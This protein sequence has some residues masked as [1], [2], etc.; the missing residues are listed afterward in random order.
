ML[1]ILNTWSNDSSNGLHRTGDLGSA[2]PALGAEQY[3]LISKTA[4]SSS[5]TL[6]YPLLVVFKVSKHKTSSK[7]SSNPSLL[8]TLAAWA[9]SALVKIWTRTRSNHYHHK[10]TWWQAIKIQ[11]V[12]SYPYVETIDE[13]KLT[14]LRRGTLCKSW[15]RT[16][17]GSRIS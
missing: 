6:S 3:S 7:Q 13:M 9:L 5:S 15:L 11:A 10:K 14:T 8:R 4:L 1:A 12:N 16:R 2:I 17:S